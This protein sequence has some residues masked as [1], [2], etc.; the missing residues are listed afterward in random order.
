MPDRRTETRL[1]AGHGTHG[2]MANVNYK[3]RP[4]VKTSQDRYL[5]R[6]YPS[7][8]ECDAVDQLARR[9]GTATGTLASRKWKSA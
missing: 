3:L 4:P 2:S 1:M 5:H 8:G 7:V 9:S 6:V